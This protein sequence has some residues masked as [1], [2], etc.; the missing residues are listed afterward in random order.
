MSHNFLVFYTSPESFFENV[1]NVSPLSVHADLDLPGQETFDIAVAG[2]MA[3]LIAVENGR[4][5]GL[6][7]VMRESG[8]WRD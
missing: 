1:I 4:E 8:V 7:R 5:S 6:E 2:E 3:S